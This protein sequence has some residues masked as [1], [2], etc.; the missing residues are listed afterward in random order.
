MI[1]AVPP[2]PADEPPVPPPEVPPPDQPPV[3]PP[4]ES[5]GAATFGL[6]LRV[7]AG[8]GAAGW[9]TMGLGLGD[10]FTPADGDDV[11]LGDAVVAAEPVAA[12]EAPTGPAALGF[13]L[14]A[15]AIAPMAMN[16]QSGPRI[17]PTIFVRFLP[18]G[19]KPGGGGIQPDG[20]GVHVGGLLAMLS[21]CHIEG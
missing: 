10:G 11:A 3:P 1:G 6:G 13:G 8:A 12:T 9:L 19:R 18:G 7:G 2:S 5:T 21:T 16:A 14:T 17:Q 4:D 20:G 15:P